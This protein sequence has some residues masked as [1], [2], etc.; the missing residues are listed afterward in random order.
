MTHI[1]D[2]I[3]A[4]LGN[5]PAPSNAVSPE[6]GIAEARACIAHVLGL[7]LDRVPR[8]ELEAD[9]MADSIADAMSDELSDLYAK[10]AR[11]EP[12]II[13]Q[14]RQAARA[15]R[16]EAVVARV[17]AWCDDLDRAVRLQHMD[18]DAE[19]PHAV[20]LR[21]VIAQEPGR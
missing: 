18:P 16:A 4:P 21:T 6:E 5:L 12:A 1:P 15:D 9:V 14:E 3:D 11:L 20:A 10:T 19:H 2:A 7:F 8:A 17:L 13:E